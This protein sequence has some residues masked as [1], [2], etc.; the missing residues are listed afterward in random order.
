MTSA[1]FWNRIPILVRRFLHLHHFFLIWLR[2][3]SL[4]DDYW[5]FTYTPSQ[6]PLIRHWLP[7]T[8]LYQAP[9]CLFSGDTT[10]DQDFTVIASGGYYGMECLADIRDGHGEVINRT[11][12]FMS[13]Q[14]MVRSSNVLFLVHLNVLSLRR[15]TNN[16][17]SWEYRQG[18]FFFAEH[19]WKRSFVGGTTLGSCLGA[20]GSTTIFFLSVYMPHIFILSWPLSLH[21]GLARQKIRWEWDEEARRYVFHS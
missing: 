7:C 3:S 11:Q 15:W 12:G 18:V 14:N 20:L 5:P 13:S 19:T 8:W 10:V 6:R 16:H 2:I 21:M 9:P 4:F 1:C 17:G